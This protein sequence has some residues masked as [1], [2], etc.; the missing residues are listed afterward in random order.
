MKIRKINSQYAW[1][2]EDWHNGAWRDAGTV[3]TWTPTKSIARAHAVVNSPALHGCRFRATLK[4]C[5]DL[6]HLDLYLSEYLHKVDSRMYPR[7]IVPDMWGEW[8]HMESEI[9]EYSFAA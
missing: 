3:Y 9:S 5:E 6:S 4:S 1:R 8:N 2:I 7:D